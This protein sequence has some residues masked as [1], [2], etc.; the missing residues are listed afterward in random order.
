MPEGAGVLMLLVVSDKSAADQ[1][2][3][4]AVPGSVTLG[5]QTRI[6]TQFEEETL[7]VY[8]L[9]DFVNAQST[10]VKTE[11][12]VFTLPKGAKN[13]T[14]LEG[15]A[16]NGVAKGASF[17]VSGPFAPGT[18]SVQLAL[19]PRSGGARGDPAGVPRRD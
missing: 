12:L 6:V 4:A 16:P 13:A 5:A 3:K 19:L 1:M 11:P 15:S 10:P 18:T 8:Y 9:F 2:A 14:V 7:Q 17:V